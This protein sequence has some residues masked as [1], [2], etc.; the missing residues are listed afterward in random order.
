MCYIPLLCRHA[1]LLLTGTF[2]YRIH[3]DMS[4]MPFDFNP[5]ALDFPALTLRCLSPPPTIFSSTQVATPTSWS[6][7]PPAQQQY[8]ALRNYFD[9]E[10]RKWRITCASATTVAQDDIQYPPSHSAL[11]DTKEA[12]LRAE[13]NADRLQTQVNDHLQAVYNAWH[14][15]PEQQ[16]QD[17]WFL[18]M[19][20]NMSTKHSQIEAMKEEQQKLRQEI[21]NLKSERDTLSRLQHP[22]EFK[23]MPPMTFPTSQKFLDFMLEESV[24][25][26]RTGI[27]FSMDGRHEDIGPVVTAAIERWKNVIVST[28]AQQNGMNAQRALDQAALANG[29][30]VTPVSESVPTA[31]PTTAADNA[32]SSQGQG[33]PRVPSNTAT[34]QPRPSIAA[35]APTVPA[36]NGTSNHSAPASDDT[37]MNEEEQ[38][39]AEGEEDEEA[40]PA[41]E[42]D[43]MSDQDADA[44]MEDDYV[45]LN[46]SQP[47]ASPQVEDQQGGR[48]EAA[49]VPSQQSGQ[50]HV[51]RTRGQGLQQHPHNWAGQQQT[52]ASGGVRSFTH[53]GHGGRAGMTM[54]T[55]HRSMQQ[56]GNHGGHNGSSGEMYVG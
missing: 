26:G 41:A 47:P 10:F 45:P 6:V 3:I 40:G 9:E 38:E 21:Q 42:E 32:A 30:P 5:L 1:G 53:A 50:L 23:I 55:P 16:K 11:N 15:L 28:R 48:Q 27:G 25:R 36:I 43:G 52:P 17:T 22:R 46:P 29:G 7:S 44:E 8:D 19:A 34:E 39:D 54:P 31:P 51:P 18:E 4:S 12:I 24:V 37:D 14:D 49:A 2:S 33:Q 13:K 35:T 20:R 56:S